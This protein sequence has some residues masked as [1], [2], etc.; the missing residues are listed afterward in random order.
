M[1]EGEQVILHRRLLAH[2]EDFF[3]LIDKNRTFFGQWMFWLD[4]VKSA[5]DTKKFAEKSIKDWD[6]K[7]SFGYSIINKNSNQLMG[8]IS[9]VDLRWEHDNAAIGYW[10]A[11]EF[12]GHGYMTEAMKLFEDALFEIGL[13]RIVLETDAENTKSFSIPERLGYKLDGILRENSF[14]N[15]AHRSTKVYSKLRSEWKPR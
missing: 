3:H 14:E 15:G 11:E 10:L 13:N 7:T 12:N 5:E 4:T 1:I 2:A 6:E 9:T 8:T